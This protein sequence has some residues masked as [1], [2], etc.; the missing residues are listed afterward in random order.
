MQIDG[1][2]RESGETVMIEHAKRAIG[3]ERRAFEGCQPT[4]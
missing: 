2:V 3:P 1:I 4:K